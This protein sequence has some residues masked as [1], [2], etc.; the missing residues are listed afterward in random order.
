MKTSRL[1]ITL[2]GRLEELERVA[3]LIDAHA[4]ARKWPDGWAMKINLCLDELITN[5]VSYG[6]GDS[7]A[8]DHE[9]RISLDESDDQVEVVMQDDGAAF[10]PIAEAPEPDLDS[11]AEDRAIGGLGIHFVKNFMDEVSWERR[12]DLNHTRLILRGLESEEG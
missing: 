2:E 3:E 12:G 9:I 10:D 4:A 8:A 5:V 11:S 1:D 6:Y 7:V